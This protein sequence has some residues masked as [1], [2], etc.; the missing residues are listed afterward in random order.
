MKITTF[1]LAAFVM[2]SVPAFAQKGNPD[3]VLGTYWNPDK[4]AQIEIFKEGDNFFGKIVWLE[5]PGKDSNNPDPDLRDRDLLGLVF[6]SDFTFNGKDTWADGSLY[7]PEDGREVRAK[8]SM[9]KNGSLK[10]RGFI[11]VSLVGKTRIFTPV[12]DS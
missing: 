10:I 4:D 6:M 11:G 12:G 2:I 7:S 9:L 3:A 1:F 8:L 5:E